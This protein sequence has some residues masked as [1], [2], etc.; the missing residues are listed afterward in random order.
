MTSE[1][2]AASPLTSDPFGRAGADLNVT[3]WLGREASGPCSDP[4]RRGVRTRTRLLNE[5]KQRIGLQRATRLRPLMHSGLE[6]LLNANH[7]RLGDGEKLPCCFIRP[8][9]WR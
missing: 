1:V 3:V 7:E 2:T 6:G 5:L 8:E 4:Q 9:C